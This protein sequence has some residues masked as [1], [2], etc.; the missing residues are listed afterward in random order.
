MRQQFIEKMFTVST[1]PELR[2]QILSTMLAA[3]GHV[4][5]S[6]IIAALAGEVWTEPPSD[7]PVLAIVKK[8]EGMP[9]EAAYRKHF[10]NVDFRVWGD[11]SHF[12]QMEKPAEFNKAVIDFVQKVNH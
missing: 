3:P 12:L 1:T 4:A 5:R 11:V 6:A 10:K 8:N 2:K 9:I 7:V